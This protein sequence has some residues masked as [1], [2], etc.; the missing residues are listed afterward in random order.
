MRQVH[1]AFGHPDEVARLIRRDCD[2]ERARVRHADVLAGKAGYAPRNIERVLA[3]FQHAR[4]PV[5]RC[6][7][8]GVAHGF[9]QRRDQVVMFFTGLVVQQRLF[10]DALLKCLGRNSD[11][12][13]VRIPVENDH[14]ERGERGACVAVCKIRDRLE[15]IRLD[16]D[17]LPAEAARVGERAGEQ[18]SEVGGGQRLQDEHLA[19]RQKRAV[20]L[21]RRVFGRRAD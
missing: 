8:I 10:G 1:R 11:S 4:E 3:C 6:V 13:A 5:D 7:R 9:V 21:E 17:F 15:H 14:F 20:D 18:G 16:I 19:T 2:F 12:I